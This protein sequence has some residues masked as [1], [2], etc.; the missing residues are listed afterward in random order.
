[1]IPIL[2]KAIKNLEEI[3]MEFHLNIKDQLDLRAMA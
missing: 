1:M 3:S 2:T